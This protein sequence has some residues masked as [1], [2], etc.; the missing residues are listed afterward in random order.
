MYAAVA[1]IVAQLAIRAVLA[2]QGYFYWDDLILISRA[3]THPLWSPAYLFDDHDGHVMPAAFLLAGA[4]AKLA[5]FNWIVP[6]VSLV[7]L[8]LVASLAIL[9]ALHVIL[10]WRPL[11]LIPL[12][13]ALFSPLSLPAF[14]WWAAALNALPMTAAMA[15]VCADA[16][17][18]LRTGN[19]RYARNGA[20]VFL[21]GLT[22]F[23]KSAVI[24]F[25]AFAVAALLAYVLGDRSAVATVWRGGRRLWIATA[26]LTAAWVGIYLLVV[27]QRRWTLDFAMTGDL[28]V[29]SVTH[30]IVPALIGGPWQWERWA[31]SSPWALP[32]WPV[33]VVG[34]LVLGAVIALSVARKEH[35]RVLW[36]A[37]AAYVVA[38]QLP[39]YLM[40]SSR[41]TAIELAQTLR[42]LPDLAVMLTLLAAVGFLAPN[43]VT[44]AR[45]DASRA[46][47]AF[48][49][50]CAALFVVSCGYSTVTFAARWRDNPTRAYVANVL[51]S[52]S[53]ANAATTAPL[54]EQEVDPLILQRFAWP[55]NL[56]GH[57]FA[58]VRDRPEFSTSTTD[59]RTFDRKGHLVDAQVTWVRHTLPGPKPQCG[60]LVQPDTPVRMPLDGPMLPTEWTA[61][62]NYLA[63]NDGSMTFALSDGDATRVPVHPG[64]NRVF[65]RLSGAG[66]AVI[67]IANTSALSVCLASG[68]VGYVAPP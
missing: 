16:I 64:L 34:W 3:G 31:P 59:L 10:G 40:R 62:I 19:Q 58:L 21:L 2:F 11:L 54:L 17:L 25:A 13:F 6:A 63:N 24:P 56:F 47:T 12:T 22:F 18:L 49:V 50:G 36:V 60:Y 51:S 26:A 41:F 53:A 46:R 9:R 14:A 7:L 68:P 5:P 1:L 43:R 30:G 52:L 28:L 35:A 27:D 29:R 33:M 20:L 38:C 15:W 8:Q 57:V 55:D 61:E 4:I 48:V 45:L 66:N 37:A 23:E 42:Y 44:S 39:I 32:Q 67:A 65:V